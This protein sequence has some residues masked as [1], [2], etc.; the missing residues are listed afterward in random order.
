MAGA[1]RYFCP[2]GFSITGASAPVAHAVP[3][4]LQVCRHHVIEAIINYLLFMTVTNLRCNFYTPT[5]RKDVF[6]SGVRTKST[7]NIAGRG[8]A[9]SAEAGSPNGWA[10]V[11]F[12]GGLRE[13]CKLPQWGLPQWGPGRSPGVRCGSP[14]LP[15]VFELHGSQS[16][17]GSLT[18]FHYPI[19]PMVLQKI[20]VQRVPTL[21]S[22]IR[23]LLTS[24]RG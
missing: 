7:V 24:Y 10:G 20:W 2:R 12:L 17:P 18:Y 6:T 8:E 9:R 11:E 5:W 19:G 21:F 14:F 1:K 22:V 3:T 15:P 4:P 16:M 13:H 23:L